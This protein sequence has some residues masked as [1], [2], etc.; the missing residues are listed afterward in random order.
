MDNT[1]ITDKS[2]IDRLAFYISSTHSD[3]G[4]E[5]VYPLGD[6]NY[7]LCTDGSVREFAWLF[8]KD[9]AFYATEE[10]A[11]EALDRHNKKEM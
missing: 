4:Y 2:F 5:L 11:Q 7:Y 10:L 6:T 8:H 9:V 3:K 1:I